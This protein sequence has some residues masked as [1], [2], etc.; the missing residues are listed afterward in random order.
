MFAYMYCVKY[1]LSI[2]EFFFQLEYII[3]KNIKFI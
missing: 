1:Q 2:I 3:R